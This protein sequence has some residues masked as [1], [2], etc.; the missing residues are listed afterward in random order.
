[1]GERVWAQGMVCKAVVQSVFLYGGDSSVVM[2]EI[3]KVIQVFHHHVV[4]KIVG[5]M[6]QLMMSG[7]WEWP[8]VAEALETAG[9][10]PSKENI[11]QRQATLAA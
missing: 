8:P 5:I 4:R 10:W 1:M 11:Q 7:E 9:I 6:A 2:G 3:L